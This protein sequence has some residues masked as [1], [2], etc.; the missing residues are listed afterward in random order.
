[1]KTSRRLLSQSLLHFARREHA[2]PFKKSNARAFSPY[3]P[4]HDRTFGAVALAILT[5]IYI[6]YCFWA[7]VTPLIDI[8]HPIL[9]IFP[10][11]EL[12]VV[13]PAY[14]GVS[15]LCAT[16][17]VVGASMLLHDPTPQKK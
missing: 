11:H 4:M 7:L 3:F 8:E 6:Y 10:N 15:V 14:A 5:F 2:Q 17:L 16:G 9:W 1:M 13:L 12:S